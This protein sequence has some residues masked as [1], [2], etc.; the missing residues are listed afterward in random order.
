VYDLERP[1]SLPAEF[2]L[3]EKGQIIN[4]VQIGIEGFAILFRVSV[5]TEG[6][7]IL[8]GDTQNGAITLFEDMCPFG[9]QTPLI[10]QGGSLGFFRAMVRDDTVSVNDFNEPKWRRS[11]IG[12]LAG[13]PQ[14]TLASQE[15]EIEP[16]VPECQTRRSK[17]GYGRAWAL[18][19]DGLRW[20]LSGRGQIF[21]GLDFLQTS[22]GGE[23]AL[24]DDPDGD[25]LTGFVEATD[26]SAANNAVAFRALRQAR[27]G[28]C[29]VDS[30]WVVG[31]IRLPSQ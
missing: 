23:F 8:D 30:T 27:T 9:A 1:A 10:L 13:A 29:S 26:V 17:L 19:A 25:T 7:A 3:T 16:A 20:F 18:T 24:F 31:F 21:T 22:I 15:G 11:V 2:D 6:T 12:E 5:P 28:D 4:S 14:T